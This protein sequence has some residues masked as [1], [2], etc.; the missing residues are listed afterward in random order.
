MGGEGGGV[1]IGESQGGWNEEGK[2]R[3]KTSS[4]FKVLVVEDKGRSGE[5]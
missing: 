1:S 4:L 3:G 5:L 2:G